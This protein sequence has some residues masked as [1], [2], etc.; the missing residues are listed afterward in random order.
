MKKEELNRKEST[1]KIFG[2]M[3][4]GDLLMKYPK[5]VEILMDEGIGCMGCGGA[6]FET[7]EQG[8]AAHGKSKEKINDI[9]E[10]MNKAVS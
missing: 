10:R 4:I 1:K 8:L 5:A 2:E 7:I 9:I 3:M 6:A